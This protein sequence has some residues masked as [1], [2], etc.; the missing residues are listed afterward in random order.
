MTFLYSYLGRCTPTH[1]NTKENSS[2]WNNEVM[3]GP[4]LTT[5]QLLKCFFIENVTDDYPSFLLHLHSF[6]K[7]Q[8]ASIKK[9]KLS[10][11]HL[12]YMVLD[13]MYERKIKPAGIAIFIF[14]I[15]VFIY[16]SL[17]YIFLCISGTLTLLNYML[18]FSYMSFF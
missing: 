13:M 12:Y 4:E 6:H 17:T 8:V 1:T 14:Y 5:F 11:I 7:S 2:F 10:F 15:L 18:L 9:M 16:F 3:A